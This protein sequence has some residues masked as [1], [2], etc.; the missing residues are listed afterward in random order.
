MVKGRG[1]D[2]E[3]T[4]ASKGP[5]TN[6]A[7]QKRKLAEGQK[8]GT[9]NKKKH[10]Q[11]STK[12]H[13]RSRT[14]GGGGESRNSATSCTSTHAPQAWTRVKEE[15]GKKKDRGIPKDKGKAPG[16]DGNKRNKRMQKRGAKRKST[17]DTPKAKYTDKEKEPD[18]EKGE[19]NDMPEGEQ[20][21]KKHAHAPKGKHAD[22][23]QV[24]QHRKE[25]ERKKEG[26]NT[27][28]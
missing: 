22:V 19:R 4:E 2:T 6:E 11:R 15:K 16:I 21:E 13:K 28:A 26:R 24:P 7:C 5:G 14:R 23:K 25:H 20:K 9:P 3:N 17:R 27:K 8:H 18:N 10:A 12:R 1:R